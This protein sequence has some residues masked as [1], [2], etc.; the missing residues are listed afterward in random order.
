MEYCHDENTDLFQIGRSSES[1][2]DFVVMDTIP[3][4]K[5]VDWNT[6]G[7]RPTISRFACRLLA[8][9]DENDPSVKVFAAGFD[10]S[11]NIFL[12]DKATIWEDQGSD[13]SCVHGLTTNGILIMKPNGGFCQDNDLRSSSNSC[14]C[15]NNTSLK[16]G[17]WREISV[18]GNIFGRR[19][20]RSAAVQGVSVPTE[21]NSL[22][23]GTL[24]D[25]CGA[26][27]LWR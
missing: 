27:L 3:G 21:D 9:R 17:T 7:T 8:N 18:D 16:P 25:L 24:I 11:K 2:I 20:P 12:G 26:T 5:I 15:P 14:L 22:T 23:D 6:V 4:N 1:P 10:S 19:E 13:E